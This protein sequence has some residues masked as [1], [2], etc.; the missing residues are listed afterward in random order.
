MLFNSYSFLLFFTILFFVYYCSP[1]K[2]RTFVLLSACLLFYLFLKWEY[3][4]I[5]FV[6]I[7]INYISSL[8]IQK[9]NDTRKKKSVF[10]INLVLNLG[11]LFFF[12]YLI[13]FTHNLNSIFSYSGINIAL[14]EYYI[15]LP[16]GLSYFTFIAL[17]Y[18]IDVYRGTSKIEKNIGIFS[19]F[20]SFF[21]TILAGPIERSTN[22]LP[23]LN[24][25]VDFDYKNITDGMKLFAWGL[26]KKI[27]IADRFALLVN[28]VYDNPYQFRGFAL[29]IAT[30]FFAIQI[31]TDFSGY[32]DMAIGIS[33]ILGF[34]IIKNFNRPY[35]SKSISEFWR[36]WHIS[37]SEWLRDYLFLPVAYSL[38]R[39]AKNGKLLFLKAE[40]SSYYLATIVTMF[41]I[42]LWHGANWNFIIWGVLFAFYLIISRITKKFRQKIIKKLNLLKNPKLLKIFRILI[43]FTL[44]CFA[45]IFFR[46]KEIID[47]F[48]IIA[49]I[50]YDLT[51]F[52]YIDYIIKSVGKIDMGIFYYM[53]CSILF[54]TLGTIELL[55]AKYNITEKISN[56]NVFIRWNIYIVFLIIIL[57]LGVS[58]NSDFLYLKF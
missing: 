11:I 52:I 5:L 43:T 46:S 30:I 21:P 58:N 15:S 35:F 37:L 40:S 44:V 48:Y 20:I 28:K 25:K 2:L 6:V 14:P 32:S 7:L 49:T 55:Q 51:K 56:L 8:Y 10:I 22:L 38:L 12:K 41:S 17:G 33:R 9:F 13:F 29:I 27:V 42:G 4:F 53:L 23:Q 50:F 45:W 39:K 24:R 31:Y 57:F 19:L 54:I 34:N 3:I 1:A 47:S 18:S 26:F 36:R 16:I